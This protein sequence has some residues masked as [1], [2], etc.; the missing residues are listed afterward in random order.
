MLSVLRLSLVASTGVCC[1]FIGDDMVV[2]EAMH[3]YYTRQLGKVE[4]A[5][6]WCSVQIAHVYQNLKTLVAK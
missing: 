4:I 3:V 6:P 5:K 1:C 2:V